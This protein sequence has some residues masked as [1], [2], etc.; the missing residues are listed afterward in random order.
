MRFFSAFYRS[1]MNDQNIHKILFIPDSN[2]PPT[3]SMDVVLVFVYVGVSPLLIRCVRQSN[4]KLSRFSAI[5]KFS[6]LFI[7]CLYCVFTYICLFVVFSFPLL[8]FFLSLSLDF[9]VFRMRSDSMLSDHFTPLHSPLHTTRNMR[10]T[11]MC[12]WFRHGRRT[13]VFTYKLLGAADWWCC[14]CCWSWTVAGS[15]VSIRF[16][17]WDSRH[18]ID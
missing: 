13:Y 7:Y 8:L 1:A 18:Q 12:T 11:T 4:C 5:C 3:D 17:M 9:L 16:L 14:C 15:F 6:N 2:I 10:M